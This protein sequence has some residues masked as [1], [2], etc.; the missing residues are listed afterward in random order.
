VKINLN[1]NFN[2]LINTKMKTQNNFT[3]HISNHKNQNLGFQMV[4]EPSKP[5]SFQKR[6]DRIIYEL[7]HSKRIS[8][9]DRY[10]ELMDRAS[11]LIHDYNTFK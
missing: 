11:F 7:S 5:I 1:Q 4:S 8:N 10:R 9:K 6:I 3:Q 2:Q